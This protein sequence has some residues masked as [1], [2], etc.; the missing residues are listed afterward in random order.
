M[1][2]IREAVER[3]QREIGRIPPASNGAHP[4]TTASSLR[5]QPDFQPRHDHQYHVSDLLRFHGADFVRNSYR[6]LLLREPDEVG[7][8]RHLDALAS[9]DQNKIDVLASLHYSQEGRQTKVKLAGLAMPSAIRRLG[10]LPLIGYLLRLTTSVAR[11]PLTLNH[12]N[13]L[14]SYLCAQLQRIVDHQN[15]FQRE[16]RD[17]LAQI[18]EGMRRVAEQ[19]DL[20]SQQ[21]ERLLT[22][23][24]E[25]RRTVEDGLAKSREFDQSSAKLIEQLTAETSQL[26]QQQESFRQSE[27]ATV[28]RQQQ[29]RSDLE[30]LVVEHQDTANNIRSQEHRTAVLLDAISRN[31]ATDSF[32]QVARQENDHLL[33]PFYAAFEDQFRGDPDEIQHR[34]EVYVPFL[35]AAQITTDVLD[36]GCG[37]GEWLRLLN[38]EGIGCQGIDRNRIF[39]EKCK[40]L[41]LNVSEADAS[42]YLQNSDS[43]SLNCVSAFHLVE[44]LPF[45]ELIRLFD[46]IFRVLRPGGLVIL[47][48]PNPENFIV[49]SCN[50]Y[51]D[52]THRNPIPNQSLQF[53]L[54]MRGFEYLDILKLRPWDEAKLQGDTE[55]I[56]RFNEFFYS[57]PDYGIIATKPLSSS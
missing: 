17:E 27:Q 52:P 10:R 16:T 37:R 23:Q 1:H 2:E 38:T 44:H 41:G 35:K 49:G 20:S 7:M 4:S 39:V 8:A 56:R 32:T 25:L 48:T 29:L 24:A 5:L 9:G 26:V 22:Q 40:R 12:Q 13:Q 57:A 31:A 19:Q 42:T 43:N 33:D 46:E 50:F 54:Q 45:G 11:L 15:Q 55:I 51:T 6:A 14:E 36:L 30:A 18:L 53:Y 28:L 47:E 3:R 34:L 21:Y